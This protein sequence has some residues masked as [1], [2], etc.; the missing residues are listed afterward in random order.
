MFAVVEPPHSYVRDA[1]ASV[2]HHGDYLNSRDDRA[3]CGLAFETPVKLGQQERAGAVC[4]DCEAKLVEYHLTWWRDRA[5]TVSAEL[6]ELRIKYR[7]LTE[8]AQ[9]PRRPP[10]G[11]QPNAQVTA[12]SPGRALHRDSDDDAEPTSLLGHARRE[13]SVLCRQFDKTVPYR[14][15]KNTMQEFSDRLS[16]EDRVALAQEIGADGSL[17]RWATTEAANLGW[18]VSGNPVHGEPEEMW[19]AWTRDSYQTP[20]PNRWR[21]GRSRSHDAG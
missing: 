19:D 21:L 12:D 3:L 18:Q 11:M 17:V 8:N 13:L 16:P 15:L 14:R 10:A 1:S 9:G 5:R 4:P 20:K 7:E 2:V 6:E